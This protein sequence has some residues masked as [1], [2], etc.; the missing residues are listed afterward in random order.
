MFYLKNA[1]N[2]HYDRKFIILI[3]CRYKLKFTIVFQK[4]NNNGY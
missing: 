3:Y 4:N 1:F 2:K